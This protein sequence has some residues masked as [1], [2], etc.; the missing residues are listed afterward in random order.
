[1]ATTT[2]HFTNEQGDICYSI[3]KEHGCDLVSLRTAIR[4]LREL[5]NPPQQEAML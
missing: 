2:L 4:Q 3:N 5:L 1:M